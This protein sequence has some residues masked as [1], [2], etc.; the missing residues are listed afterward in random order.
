MEQSNQPV[1]NKKQLIK[2]VILAGLIAA[3]VLVVAVLPAEYG[4]DITGLGKLFGFD[5]LYVNQETQ[6]NIDGTTQ[7]VPVN[8]KR[9][10]LE[11]LGSPSSVPKPSGALNPPPAEQLKLRSDVIEIKVPSGKGLEYKFRALKLGSVKYDWSTSNNN[12]VYIDFHGEVHEENPPEEV[13]YE[14]YTLAF[15]NNMA[16]TFTSPFEGKHG[17]Y[18]RNRNAFDVTVTLNLQGQYELL[19]E[20]NQDNE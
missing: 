4:K 13:F 12:I 3:V 14:S 15:S 19:E 10:K 20:Y 11:Q 9:L 16:G 7:V 5:K 2:S 17:W 1:M 18:F 6:E 8:V